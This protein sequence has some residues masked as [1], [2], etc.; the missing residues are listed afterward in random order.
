MR[1]RVGACTSAGRHRPENQDYLLYRLAT[2]EPDAVRHCSLFVAADGVGGNA[3]GDIASE[4]AA[5]AVAAAFPRDG[6]DEPSV[7]LAAAISAAGEAV[8]ARASA[9]RALAGMATTLVAAVV[10]DGQVWM[11]N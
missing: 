2:A 9:E 8:T 4:L 11:A 1:L 7:R 10:R 3:G 5:K 6:G